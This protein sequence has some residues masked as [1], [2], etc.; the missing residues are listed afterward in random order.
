MMAR[1]PDGWV[2]TTE[3]NKKGTEMRLKSSRELVM[4]KNCKY[5]EVKDLWGN[6]GGV[7]V[8]AASDVPTCHKWSDGCMTEPDGYCFMGE[9]R[10]DDGSD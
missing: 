10:D 4:C 1:M 6:F 9:R 7:S 2:I 5:Y 8:L 3:S